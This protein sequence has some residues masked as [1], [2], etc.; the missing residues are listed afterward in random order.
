MPIMNTTDLKRPRGRPSSFDHE[1]VLEKALT[2]FWSR[3]YEGASMAELTQAMGLNRPSIY[4]AFGNK[5][6]LFHRALGKYLSGSVAYVAEAMAEPTARKVVE[7]FLTQSAEFLSDQR[8]PH[9]CMVV[10]G[11]LS[12]GQGSEHIRRELISYRHGYEDALRRRFD[13]AQAQSDLPVGANTSDLAKYIATIHQGMS[14]QATSGATKEQL[15]AVV[16]LTLENWPNGVG[17]VD[18]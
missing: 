10:Q 2:V 16:R 18:K 12:C 13:Q 8:H 15:Q 5:E 3:G 4:A 1:E 17:L 7:K 14:V 11:A 9:G 6:A